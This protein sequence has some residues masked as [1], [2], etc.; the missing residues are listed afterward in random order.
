MQHLR[1]LEEIIDYKTTADDGRKKHLY[2]LWQ[3]R[4]EY[5]PSQDFEVWQKSLNLRSLVIDKSEEIASY[6]KFA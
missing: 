3:N 4:L 1:E 5:Q 6:L 2:A